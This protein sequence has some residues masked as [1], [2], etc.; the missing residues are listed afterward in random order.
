MG[1]GAGVRVPV[2]VQPDAASHAL[3]RYSI[4]YHQVEQL[5][6]EEFGQA[7]EME[8]KLCKCNSAAN[9]IMYFT[10]GFP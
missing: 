9:L 7:I 10:Q 4:S 2:C 8:K 6:T 3:S 5:V 1:V